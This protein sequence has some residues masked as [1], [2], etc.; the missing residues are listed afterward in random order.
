M[1]LKSPKAKAV[2]AEA[3]EALAAQALA[4]LAGDGVRISAFLRETG[5][6]PAMLAQSAGSRETLGAVLD[7][8]IRDESLLLTFAADAGLRPE[9]VIEAHLLLQGPAP[10][11]ST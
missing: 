9:A 2:T 7:Y 11:W 6:D 10:E 1:R 4:F 8:V 5:L 3:A